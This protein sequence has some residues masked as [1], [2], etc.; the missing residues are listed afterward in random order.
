MSLFWGQINVIL[1]ILFPIFNN[2]SFIQEELPS[3]EATDDSSLN[4][5]AVLHEEINGE[6]MF[7]FHDDDRRKKLNYRTRERLYNIPLYNE[8][9]PNR[10]P[11][12]QRLTDR[13][14]ESTQRLSPS[15]RGPADTYI[16]WK[17]I[18]CMQFVS[19][20]N[21]CSFKQRDQITPY[22]FTYKMSKDNGNF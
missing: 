5:N 18:H 15:R 7:E 2:L 13:L 21:M 12:M 1:C 11:K 10:P 20:D 16:F 19:Y 9:S 6:L 17:R 3:V 14:Q 4:D 22:L 8:T